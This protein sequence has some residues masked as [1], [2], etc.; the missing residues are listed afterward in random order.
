MNWANFNLKEEK[1]KDGNPTFLTVI[2]CLFET[3]NKEDDESESESKSGS[4]INPRRI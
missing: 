2:V 4:H 3:I 1:R